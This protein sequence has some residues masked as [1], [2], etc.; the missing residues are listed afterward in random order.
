[1]I[2]MPYSTFPADSTRPLRLHHPSFR[3][4][5]LDEKR[6]GEFWVD[7]KRAHQVLA[8][9]CIRL[10]S[11]SL[12]QDVLGINRPGA[13]ATEVNARHVKQCLPAEVQ[14]ACLYWIQHLQKSGARLFDSDQVH[15]FLKG[16]VLEGACSPLARGPGVDGE[17]SG[18]SAID[19]FTPYYHNTIFIAMRDSSLFSPMHTFAQ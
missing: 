3:D 9:K 8:D 10:M 19:S 5:L 7:E 6:C 17:G 15:Q 12:K 14:Y 18:R 4:F 16:Q 1:M 2:F 11:T 13:L